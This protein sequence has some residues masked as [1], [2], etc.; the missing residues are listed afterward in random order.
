MGGGKEVTAGRVQSRAEGTAQYSSV[1]RLRA[2]G[3][4]VKTSKNL[5]KPAGTRVQPRTEGVSVPEV[6]AWV[7]MQRLELSR[8]S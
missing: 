4:A 1:R 5:Q 8:V 6:G 3:S 2:A 7:V